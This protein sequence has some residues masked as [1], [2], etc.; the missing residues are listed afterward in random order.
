MRNEWNIM[1][2]LDQHKTD[3]TETPSHLW[4]ILCIPRMKRD[5]FQIKSAFEI[6]CSDDISTEKIG[7]LFS[8]F[9]PNHVVKDS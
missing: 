8:I 7:K 5:R 6:D 3:N 2:R 1:E 9:L 4:I